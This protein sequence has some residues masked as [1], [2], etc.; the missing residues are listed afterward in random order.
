MADMTMAGLIAPLSFSAGVNFDFSNGAADSL[1]ESCCCCVYSKQANF[2]SYIL[3]RMLICIKLQF[4]NSCTIQVLTICRL[5]RLCCAAL[6]QCQCLTDL[7]NAHIAIIADAALC[8]LMHLDTAF[9]TLC[10]A[11]ECCDLPFAAADRCAITLPVASAIFIT[12]PRCTITGKKNLYQGKD[13]TRYIF[14]EG[15]ERRPER[16][17]STRF[18]I[19][20][21]LPVDYH[22]RF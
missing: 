21:T 17:S 11:L 14:L 22:K 15:T 19:I 9:K 8:G 10:R 4:K 12:M 1:S 2:L 5:C 16:A 3:P 20:H 13:P 18:T 7:Y 6:C